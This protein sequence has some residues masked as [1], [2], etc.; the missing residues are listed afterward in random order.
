MLSLNMAA[1]DNR[2]YWHIDAKWIFGLAFSFFLLATTLI[3]ILDKLTSPEVAIP[4]ATYIVASQFSRQGLDDPTE[5][6]KIKQ[7]LSSS[8]QTRFYPFANNKNVFVTRED[9]QTLSPK[10]IR[11]KIFRQIIEPIYYQK[12]SADSLKQ[13]GILAKIN[14]STN[15]LLHRIFLISLLPLFLSLA[16]L[17]YFSWGYGKLISPA[18]PL[19]VLGLLPS[20]FLFLITHANPPNGESGPV[21]FIPR[22]ILPT[23]TK[24]LSFLFNLYV[25]VG[26][27]LLVI[28][29]FARI[30]KKSTKKS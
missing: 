17:I 1:P 24:P 7:T 6:N 9:I 18:V 25:L 27:A 15:Q 20:M 11:L 10:E 8:G 3:Y 19:L 4:T 16:G 29:I 2:P 26:V 5:I 21:S 14:N 22:D 12:E 28:A 30:V 23:L 13:Y